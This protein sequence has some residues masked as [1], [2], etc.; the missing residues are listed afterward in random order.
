[1]K[2]YR[3]TEND[4]F[5]MTNVTPKKSGLPVSIWS[6]HSGITRSVL[7]KDTPR[8]KVSYGNIVISISIEENPQIL[9]PKAK[10]IPK[11]VM[12]KLQEGIDY[13][14]RNYD[15]FLKHYLDQDD[16]FDDEDLFNALRE[17]KEYK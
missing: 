5:G 2:I 3:K 9:A 16:S 4:V 12:K 14:S 17:R 10:K 15:L 11:D 13:F 1:M 7:H 6:D 8:A